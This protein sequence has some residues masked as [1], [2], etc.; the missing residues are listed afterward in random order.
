VPRYNPT[1]TFDIGIILGGIASY[2]KNTKAH[3]FNKHADR[4]IEAEQLYHKGIIKKILLSGGNGMLFNNDYIEADAMRLHLLNNQIP[5]EDIIIENTSRNTKE[6][7]FNSALILKEKF[8]SS[9]F[10]LITSAKHM[11]RAKFC[12]EK[13]SIKVT[14]FP[15]DCTTSYRSSGIE[16]LLLPKAQALDQWENLIH[17]W[18]G[19]I[20]YKIIL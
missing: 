7:A 1:Q 17:E 19:Y 5:S 12:F 20:V 10:L 8:P 11:R 15:T 4:L 13:A 16:Y 2:D 14:A 9:K 3:N 18:I 6:N